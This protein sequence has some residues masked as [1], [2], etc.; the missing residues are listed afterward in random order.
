MGVADYFALKEAF[1]QQPQPSLAA[2]SCIFTDKE[3]GTIAKQL[4]ADE[5]KCCEPLLELAKRRLLAA[6]ADMVPAGAPGAA[7]IS[8]RQRRR[9]QGALAMHQDMQQDLLQL[10]VHC[11][12][13]AVGTVVG[14]GGANIKRIGA[15][16]G[17]K[18]FFSSTLQCFMLSG[19]SEAARRAQDA[20]QSLVAQFKRD[21][22]D[23]AVEK[24]RRLAQRLSHPVRE[25]SQQVQHGLG[26]PD[27]KEEAGDLWRRHRRGRKK[28][29]SQHRQRGKID[30][31]RQSTAP[32][33]RRCAPL[34]L[35][36]HGR[37]TR[38][39]LGK[40]S[41]GKRP[42]RGANSCVHTQMREEAR[43]HAE[44]ARGRE[45]E[46]EM[47]MEME[48]EY[49]LYARTARRTRQQRHHRCRE[50]DQSSKGGQ[51]QKKAAPE[52][53]AAFQHAIAWPELAASSPQLALRWL[54]AAGQRCR[55]GVE[56]T[57]RLDAATQLQW[58]LLTRSRRW[59]GL[60]Q[61]LINLLRPRF[62]DAP[63]ALKQAFALCENTAARPYDATSS[64]REA[65]EGSVGRN[66]D[67]A[68]MQLLAPA[69]PKGRGVVAKAAAEEQAARFRLGRAVELLR[70]LDLTS[71]EDLSRLAGGAQRIDAD[72]VPEVALS[73][74]DTNKQL[75]LAAQFKRNQEYW[76]V[77]KANMNKTNKQ[78]K[79]NQQEKQ[80]PGQGKS[81]QKDQPKQEP[82]KKQSKP[83]P[84]PAAKPPPPPKPK[85]RRG[86]PRL[87]DLRL[88]EADDGTFK[89]TIL[90]QKSPKATQGKATKGNVDKRKTTPAER[91]EVS[92]T[93]G[94]LYVAEK[95]A[96]VRRA[97]ELNSK[98]VR[99]SKSG[100]DLTLVKDELVQV[101]VGCF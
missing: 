30:S 32:G 37:A 44:K 46:N 17:C 100:P 71:A 3:L 60:V 36:I 96:V 21:Q 67:A 63:F 91:P 22:E 70:A 51:N 54:T 98:P 39:L 90:V 68:L 58:E 23:W 93:L 92:Y 83:K 56:S 97:K 26:V 27:G 41:K 77:S 4:G 73:A 74:G 101:R 12:P 40:P 50:R 59:G 75:S 24:A 86:L 8:Y 79:K 72:V 25:D 69:K 48:M 99:E 61:Q 16:L 87:A 89:L 52:S 6:L 18:I 42:A 95:D 5:R 38:R 82:Q 10:N 14:R 55:G 2:S 7:T 9:Q 88:K 15:Q 80:Q 45:M 28:A 62:A 65:A 1:L 43:N 29:G 34:K 11:S 66:I 64:A 35:D 53:L 57:T 20:L 94:T 85:T 81:K 78:G 49:A 84:K 76:A 33:G 19:S 13:A 31:R 47:E